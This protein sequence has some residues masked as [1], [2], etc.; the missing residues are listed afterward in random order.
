MLREGLAY[1][2][3]SSL[4]DYLDRGMLHVWRARS[5]HLL[6]QIHDAILIQFDERKEDDVIQLVR[7]QLEF[8]IRLKGNRLFSIPY[9]V[10]TGWNW[11]PYSEENPDGLKTYEPGDK[12]R[13]SPPTSLLDRRFYRTYRK[14]SSYS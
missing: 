3:Q 7:K 9:G 11:G 12:R 2:A 4:A 8:P 5:C 14:V 1:Q 6:M 13:R 10:K